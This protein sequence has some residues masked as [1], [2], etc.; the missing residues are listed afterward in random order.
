MNVSEPTCLRLAQGLLL[1]GQTQE[2]RRWTDTFLCLPYMAIGWR[3]V[4]TGWWKVAVRAIQAFLV[5]LGVMV[6]VCYSVLDFSMRS[7]LWVGWPA[8]GEVCSLDSPWS[9]ADARVCKELKL[10]WFGD[11]IIQF[12]V[13]CSDIPGA[14]LANVFPLH[15]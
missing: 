9:H 13:L 11:F 14:C 12:W 4:T 6:M 15:R 5:G 7:R 8:G 2:S 1:C 3:L 10:V